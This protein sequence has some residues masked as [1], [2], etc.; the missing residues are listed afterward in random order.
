[1]DWG[2]EEKLLKLL[3][4]RTLATI[5]HGLNGEAQAEITSRQG[6]A[7]LDWDFISPETAHLQSWSATTDF[8]CRGCV[9]RAFV[10]LCLE[11]QEDSPLLSQLGDSY[12]CSDDIGS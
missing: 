10:L 2:A 1:M 8:A 6:A 3:H 5:D 4:D 9:K 7:C 11:C 12:S